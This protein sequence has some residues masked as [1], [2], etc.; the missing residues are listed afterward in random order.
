MI[1]FNIVTIIINS[2][3]KDDSYYYPQIYLGN[4]FYNYKN[5]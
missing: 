1:N 3:F 2:V 5:E 4:C